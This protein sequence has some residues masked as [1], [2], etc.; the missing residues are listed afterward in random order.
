M[1]L[2]YI[3]NAKAGETVLF[4]GVMYTARDAAHKLIF[5]ALK[6]NKPLPFD[7]KDAA[8]YYCGACPEKPGEVI[9]SCGPTTSSRMDS[10]TPLLIENGLK[11]MIGK[12]KRSQEVVEAMKKHG[13]VYLCAV[14]GAGALIKSFVTDSRIV[15]YPEL[16]SEAVLRLTVKNLPLIVGIDSTGNSILH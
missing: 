3:L 4:S 2:Q 5:E 6:Q 16:L 14:G 9:G 7:L 11:I 15:A 13:A 10:Y 1:S 8:I 12:G